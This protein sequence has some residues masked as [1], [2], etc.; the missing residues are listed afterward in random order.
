MKRRLA[1]PVEQAAA[2]TATTPTTRVEVVGLPRAVAGRL[3]A[4]GQVTAALAGMPERASSARLVFADENGPKGGVA[5]RC[6]V[7]VSLAGWGRVHVE[8]RATT[9]RLALS[10][11]LVRLERSLRRRREIDRVRSRRPKKY[12]AAARALEGSPPPRRAAGG[13]RRRGG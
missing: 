11:A 12:Y 2:R 9:P 6:A 5:V 8:D 10:G 1:S 3:R 4:A 13:G 7:T